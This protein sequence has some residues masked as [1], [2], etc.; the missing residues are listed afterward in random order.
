MLLVVVVE[1]V[2]VVLLPWW[3]Q[4]GGEFEGLGGGGRVEH[5]VGVR[6][7]CLR[8]SMEGDLRTGLR[9]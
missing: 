3:L 7:G 2:L 5:T 8:G 9:G 6:V 1:M 4:Q